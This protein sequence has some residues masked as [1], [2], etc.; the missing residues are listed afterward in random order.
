[1]AHQRTTA[2]TRYYDALY[3]DAVQRLAI[4]REQTYAE[5]HRNIAERQH[6]HLPTTAQIQSYIDTRRRAQR[7]QGL[8]PIRHSD[9]HQPASGA[10]PERTRPTGHRNDQMAQPTAPGVEYRPFPASMRLTH[11]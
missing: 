4:V 3:R 6:A 7:A 9:A 5:I 1:M 8:R 10:A 11:R 2:E